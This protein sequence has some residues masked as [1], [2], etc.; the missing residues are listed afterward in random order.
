MKS[1]AVIVQNIIQ[2]YSVRQIVQYLL[3][4]KISVDVLVYDPSQTSSEFK[5]FHGIAL[6]TAKAI[7][8]D[9]VVVK[10][11]PK[12]SQYHLC[13]APYSDMINFSCKYRLCYCYGAITT[14]PSATLQ[15]EHKKHFH[16]FLIHDTYTAELVGVYGRSYIVPD[17]YLQPITNIN[18]LKF[19]L[20]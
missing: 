17:L 14:K 7:K 16:G 18:L 15:P 3:D 20:S 5:D 12:D 9:G 11:W 8:K 1:V 2:W 10:D 19:V 6:D 13:L 4:K